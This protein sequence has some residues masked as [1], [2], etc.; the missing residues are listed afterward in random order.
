M[1]V[2]PR[3]HS[4][5]RKSTLSPVDGAVLKNKDSALVGEQSA[6]IVEFFTLPHSRPSMYPRPHPRTYT[7][8]HIILTHQTHTHV[9]PYTHTHAHSHAH[10]HTISFPPPPIVWYSQ[11]IARRLSISSTPSQSLSLSLC[12]LNTV[13]VGSYPLDTTSNTLLCSHLLTF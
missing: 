2:C 12:S 10:A 4:S 1:M 6:D 9:H 7:H 13:L 8:K 5:N 11:S 3:L